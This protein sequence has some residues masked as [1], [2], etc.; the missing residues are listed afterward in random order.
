MFEEVAN[1]DVE[2]MCQSRRWNRDGDSMEM[3]RSAG[4]PRHARGTR[5]PSK[6][7]RVEFDRQQAEGT[8]YSRSN[9]ITHVALLFVDFWILH[10]SMASRQKS[11]FEQDHGAKVRSNSRR[12]V[13][14][15]PL[16]M[17]DSQNHDGRAIVVLTKGL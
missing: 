2:S 3:P 5:F 16:I 6:V 15:R 7:K 13:N 17:R 14:S 9:S 4:E 12:R 1:Q 11:F 10:R 8:R